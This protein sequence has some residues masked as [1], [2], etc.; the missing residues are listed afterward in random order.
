LTSGAASI[1]VFSASIERDASGSS[2]VDQDEGIPEPGHDRDGIPNQVL[3]LMNGDALRGSDQELA[4]RADNRRP[5][6]W[7]ESGPFKERTGQGAPGD[8]AALPEL[9]RAYDYP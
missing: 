5:V 4:G 6:P 1:G 9:L 8:G 2:A 3:R 7:P